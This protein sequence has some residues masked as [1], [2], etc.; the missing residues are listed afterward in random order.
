[1]SPKHDDR[2]S[3]SLWVV[4][5]TIAALALGGLVIDGGYAMSA[6]REA[7][8]AAEQAARAG[9]DQLDLDSI[10]SGGSN[11]NNGAAAAAARSYLS[12]AGESG[13]VT[14]RGPQVT[15][16]VTKRHPSI[17]LS[18]FG[19]DGITVSSRASATSI[20]GPD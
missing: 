19:Q 12:T 9:S 18:A 11:L 1:M 3:V 16:T 6:K 8:R 10:R 20:D 2:G 5:M 14:V 7:A 15:V 13:S 4:F 17:L